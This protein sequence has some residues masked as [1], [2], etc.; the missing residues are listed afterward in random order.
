MRAEEVV[1]ARCAYALEDSGVVVS[2]SRERIL[3]FRRRL[4]KRLERKLT[5]IGKA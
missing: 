1:L 2:K 4:T 5:F 3:L